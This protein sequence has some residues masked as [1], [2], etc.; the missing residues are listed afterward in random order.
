M[1]ATRL[2]A[3]ILAAADAVEAARDELG[4]LDAVAGDGDHGVTL[5]LA[6]RSVRAR[7]DGAPA[8]DGADLLAAI[9]PA[10]A[11]V[12][13]SI[14]PIYATALLRLATAARTLPAGAAPT[15]AQAREAAESVQAGIERLGGAR[16]GDKTVLDALAP[17]VA[18]L[19]AA[20]A[21]GSSLPAALDAAVEAARVG[22]ASTAD[23]VARVGRASRLGEKSLGSPDPGATSFALILASAVRAWTEAPGGDGA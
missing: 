17:A 20:E 19:G 11:S 8:L 7:L 6:A 2:R 22:A 4:R 1:T 3:C 23:M 14:G 12:G 5:A 21:G 16:P 18:A 9:A 10:V 13:G 15:V